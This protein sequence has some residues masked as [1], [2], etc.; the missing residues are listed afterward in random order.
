MNVTQKVKELAL[1]ELLSQQRAAGGTVL[2]MADLQ[3][4]WRGTGLRRSDLA[5]AVLP[6]LERGLFERVADR[7][8]HLRVTDACA[9]LLASGAQP[10]DASATD[11]VRTKSEL[12]KARTR[13]RRGNS[14]RG[15]KRVQ[16]R[17]PISG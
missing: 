8:G 1:L 10:E 14:Q 2:A 13:P 11:Y 16:D 6:L 17:Q 7:P 3:A 9:A 5:E 12:E 4:L 15:L